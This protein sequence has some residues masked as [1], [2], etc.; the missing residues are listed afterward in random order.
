LPTPRSVP[1]TSTHTR[2]QLR[3]GTGLLRLLYCY[4]FYQIGFR[5]GGGFHLFK[6][7]H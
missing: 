1:P 6:G 4:F 2:Q 3:G 7:V 5:R